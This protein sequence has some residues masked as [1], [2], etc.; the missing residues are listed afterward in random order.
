[1]PTVFGCFLLVCLILGVVLVFA[2]SMI[3]MT[4][5]MHSF[6]DEYSK[7]PTCLCQRSFLQYGGFEKVT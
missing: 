5:Q 2:I 7:I 1:M 6:D 4:S 3:S